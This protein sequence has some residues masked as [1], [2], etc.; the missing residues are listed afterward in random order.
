[1][2]RWLLLLL[3]VMVAAC[4]EEGPADADEDGFPS[5]VDC[6]DSNTEVNPGAEEVCGDGLAND[7][8]GKTD[9]DDPVCAGDPICEPIEKTPIFM[10][11][12][13]PGD[14]RLTRVEENCRFCHGDYADYAPYDTWVGTMMAQAARDPLALALI[15]VEN[16]ALDGIAGDLCFRC[17]SPKGWLEGRSEPVS[18]ALLMGEDLNGVQCDLC[19]RL[20]DPLSEE[21]KALVEPDVTEP[22][23][24]RMVV[25]PESVQRGPYGDYK[26]AHESVKSEFTMSSE[27]CATCHDIEHPI[28]DDVPIEKTYS[29]WKYSAFSREGIQCQD[30]H[31]DPGEGY[32][33]SLIHESGEG[34]QGPHAQAHHCWR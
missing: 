15:A 22:G 8:N 27:F 33:C 12:T 23:T 3:I 14:V 7:C 10:P 11:G 29:E 25:S 18:G 5:D 6:D 19:H 31:M 13:Q 30:C 24:G 34:L 26:G 1:V 9:C 2:G 17:H 28:Y 16:K 4:V 21:G 32:A 20:V